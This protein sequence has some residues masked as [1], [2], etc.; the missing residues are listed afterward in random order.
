MSDNSYTGLDETMPSPPRIELK[1]YIE[2]GRYYPY[3]KYE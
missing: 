3:V 1:I 2:D